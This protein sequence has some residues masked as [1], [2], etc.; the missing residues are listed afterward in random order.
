MLNIQDYIDGEKRSTGFVMK[1][2]VSQGLSKEH[3]IKKIEEYKQLKNV[4]TKRAIII[5]GV[6]ALGIAT[7]AIAAP[8]II[9]AI[10]GGTL[11]LGGTLGIGATHE[12]KAA[13]RERL[14]TFKDRLRE[15]KADERK[16]RR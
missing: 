5:A 14:S 15:I 3:T 4:A 7:L 1:S 10:A 2:R 12:D 9:A 16:S 13:I 6:T 8:T 11:G